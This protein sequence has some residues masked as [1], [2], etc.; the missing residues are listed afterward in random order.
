[1]FSETRINKLVKGI[2]ILH[3][4]ED[5]LVGDSEDLG[6]DLS[7]NLDILRVSRISHDL[8]DDLE[9]NLLVGNLELGP[10]LTHHLLLDLLFVLLLHKHLEHQL[11]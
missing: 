6:I 5:L 4:F 2:R 9:D 8:L 3:Q 1:L 10:S 7:E 11:V